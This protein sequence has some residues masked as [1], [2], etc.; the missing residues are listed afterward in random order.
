MDLDEVNPDHL[1]SYISV[2]ETKCEAIISNHLEP[3]R[4]EKEELED[5]LEVVPEDADE[6]I[7]N[8][9]CAHITFKDPD[10][11]EVKD[12]ARDRLERLNRRFAYY[13]QRLDHFQQNKERA[14]RRMEQMRQGELPL[15][16]EVS[17]DE[18]PPKT[19][20]DA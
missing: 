4:R 5:F 20:Y 16:E 13:K 3:I 11:E 9:G 10:P 6:I 15:G 2:M 18:D 12:K 7:L 19:V 17:V 1:E 14:F 8:L